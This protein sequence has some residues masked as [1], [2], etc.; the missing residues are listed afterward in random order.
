MMTDVKELPPIHARHHFRQA[1]CYNGLLWALGNGLA[2]TT[3]IYYLAMELCAAR[4]DF[5]KARLGLVVALILAA[6]KI[7]GLLRWATPWLL[8][9]ARS[10][11]WFCFFCYLLAPLFLVGVP[12]V[13]A[14]FTRSEEAASLGWALSLLV[15][16]WCLYHLAEYL[17]SVAL[18]SWLGDG[19]PLRIRGRFFGKRNRWLLTGQVAGMIGGG[20]YTWSTLE[21]DPEMARWKAYLMPA[22]A[23]IFFLLL[24]TVPL[25]A[26]PEIARVRAKAAGERI[27][28]MIAPLV[29]RRFLPLLLFGAWLSM[30][31][32]LTQAAQGVFPYRVLGFGV[33]TMLALKSG[34]MIAQWSVSGKVGRWVDRHGNRLIMTVSLFLVA[35]GPLFYMI[36]D[37]R[38]PWWMVGAWVMWVAWVGVNVALPNLVL[39]MSPD[40]ENSPA[41]AAYYSVSGLSM[42]LATL[43]GGVLLDRWSDVVFHLPGSESR[44]LDYYQLQFLAGWVLRTLA[45]VLLMVLVRESGPVNRADGDRSLPTLPP[46]RFRKR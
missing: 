37:R 39:K 45:A 35:A 7:A 29:D 19:V 23:G 8:D 38:N 13:P 26:M 2:S 46:K 28:R 40:R 25:A 44:T 18:W 1:A 6:P 12:L 9:W 10:R 32:G 36:A 11:K 17:G 21:L 33:L 5:D 15:A 3:L 27:R 16:S 42:A 41:L 24:S 43:L 14:W 30:A 31:N 4:F 20:L 22:W 34:L